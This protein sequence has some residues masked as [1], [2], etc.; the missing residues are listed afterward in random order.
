MGDTACPVAEQSLVW[1]L[2]LFILTAGGCRLLCRLESDHLRASDGIQKANNIEDRRTVADCQKLRKSQNAGDIV[3]DAYPLIY[4]FSM[5]RA[6][7]YRERPRAIG[8]ED[9]TVRRYKRSER[10]LTRTLE[11]LQNSTLGSA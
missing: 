3:V 7:H 11:T 8:L 9:V 4:G 2:V 5:E 10:T 1:R 6:R